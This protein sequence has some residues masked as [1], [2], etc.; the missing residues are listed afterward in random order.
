MHLWATDTD[1]NF[2]T[3]TGSAED[4]KKH[5]ERLPETPQQNPPEKPP[6]PLDQKALA[7]EQQGT[8]TG[9]VSRE[10][11]SP[12][13]SD[14]KCMS[15]YYRTLLGLTLSPGTLKLFCGVVLF[16]G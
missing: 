5:E 16:R 11:W 6:G 1:Y 7:E 10:F 15:G 12:A 13:C 4:I 2:L 9:D 8:K 14:G 3:D